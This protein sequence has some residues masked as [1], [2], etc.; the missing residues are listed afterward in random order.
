VYHPHFFQN[1]KRLGISIF[2][3]FASPNAISALV[4]GPD[5]C[6]L[7]PR[8]DNIL[9]SGPTGWVSHLANAIAI[10]AIKR[11][12]RVPCKP[13]HQLL[14]DLNAATQPLAHPPIFFPGGQSFFLG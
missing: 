11:E 2:D 10:E 6:A 12:Y 7:N 8:N 1:L 5:A 4:Q 3:L 13:A 9:F 14:S